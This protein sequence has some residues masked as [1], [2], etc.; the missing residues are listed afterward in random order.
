MQEANLLDVAHEAIPYEDVVCVGLFQPSG[1][2]DGMSLG[3]AG[4]EAQNV[5]RWSLVAVTPSRVCILAV[6]SIVPYVTVSHP[7][8]FAALDRATTVAHTTTRT[9]LTIV[10]LTDT[11]TGLQYRFECPTSHSLGHAAYVIKELDAQ[12]VEKN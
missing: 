5:P 7:R 10:V 9:A 12:V 2:I 4:E 11:K 1:A 3:L 6:R 8:L